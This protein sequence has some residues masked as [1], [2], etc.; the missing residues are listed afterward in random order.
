[1]C[2]ESGRKEGWEKGRNESKEDLPDVVGPAVAN[3]SQG[4]AKMSRN[5]TVRQWAR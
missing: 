5:V 1:M 3:L 2:S 4:K